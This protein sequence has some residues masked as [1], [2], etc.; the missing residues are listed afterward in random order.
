[1]EE[2]EDEKDEEK[3]KDVSL[4]MIQEGGGGEEK[5]LKSE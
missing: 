3:I 1:M 4:G 2:E 5:R